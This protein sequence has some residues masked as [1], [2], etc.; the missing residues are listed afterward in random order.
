MALAN[1]FPSFASTVECKD[2]IRLCPCR[3]SASPVFTLALSFCDPNC[4]PSEHDLPLECG[5]RAEDRQHH[6]SSGVA[7][8]KFMFKMRIPTSLVFK[9]S[10]IL[11]P[12]TPRRAEVFGRHA[13]DLVLIR[14][15]A[16]I[17]GM[18]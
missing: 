6:F 5:N 4:L 16:T 13:F 12:H 11:I 17:S 10:M 3:R 8:S 2:L 7:S 1:R 9:V 18:L 15:N 14:I